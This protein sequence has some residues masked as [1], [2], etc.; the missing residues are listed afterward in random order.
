MSRTNIDFTKHNYTTE[1]YTNTVGK[2]IRVDRL[3][4]SNDQCLMIQFMNTDKNLIV[5]GDFGD[6]IFSRPFHPSAKGMAADNYWVEKLELANNNVELKQNLDW[7][8]IKEQIQENIVETKLEE[9]QEQIE[10]WQELLDYA[11]NEDEIEYIRFA[12]RESLLESEQIP[13]YKLMPSQLLVVFDA[14]NIICKRIAEQ[15]D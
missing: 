13:M 4:I 8:S 3:Q 11:D 6:W 1:K 10:L 2:E 12:Y 7:V 14:F 9:D 15:E 5:T